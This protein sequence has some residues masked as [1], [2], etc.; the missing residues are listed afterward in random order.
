MKGHNICSITIT[1]GSLKSR[2]LR[3]R[4]CFGGNTVYSVGRR[5]RSVWRR[6]HSKGCRICLVRRHLHSMGCRKCFT[7]KVSSFDGLK[8]VFSVKTSLFDELEK[9]FEWKYVFIRLAVERICVGRRLHSTGWRECLSGKTSS[10]DGF[11]RVL[12]VDLH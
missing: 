10:F 9:M 12:S 3:K 6:I 1:D 5:T 2:C 7:A 4:T 11:E 8:N